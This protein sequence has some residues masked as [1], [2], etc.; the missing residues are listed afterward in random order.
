VK[1]LIVA[2]TFFMLQPLLAACTAP[3]LSA[4][5]GEIPL[6]LP[7]PDVATLIDLSEQARELARE[8]VP[9]PVLRQLTTDL[10]STGFLFTDKPATVEVDVIMPEPEAPPEKWSVVVLS[11]SKLVGHTAQELGLEELKVGPERVA[12]A[13]KE[14]WPDC[15]V[16]GMSLIR[17]DSLRW[18]GFCNT[19]EG[20]ISGF[21]DNET[22]VF[23]P[24]A[25]PPALPPAVATS[26]AHA[27][28]DDLP[29]TCPVT[30]APDRPFSPPPPYPQSAPYEGHFWYGT[31][32]LW[33]M[34]PVDG[35]WD[36]L[37]HGEKVWWWRVGY[38]G[39]DEPQP[40]LRATARRL[41]GVASVAESGPPATNGY[42]PDFHWAMLSG[43]QV[44]TP[45][46][47]EVTGHYHDQALS[48]VVWVAP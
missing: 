7:D 44:A 3:A 4:G 39:S 10:H 34:L 28:P 17:E 25:A 11:A 45:G 8:E 43:L 12:R 19:I 48:F 15:T 1:V 38:D 32:S 18:V 26:T 47:W 46:C 29:D 27:L 21:V 22:A 13:M 33:T 31:E 42:H 20:V 24:S 16:R 6:K 40:E 37:A 30:T 36:Q 23:E 5:G 41:D 9:D 35:Q 14:Q 2:L